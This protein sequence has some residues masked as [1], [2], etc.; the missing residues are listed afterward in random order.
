MATSKSRNAEQ[1]QREI[2]SERERL[3]VAVDDLRDGIDRV[4]SLKGKLPVAIAAAFGVGF[5]A[6][7]GVGATMRLLMGR[8]REGRTKSRFGPFSRVGRD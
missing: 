4:T 3:A 8:G 1:V 6:A 7:G 5:V 2:E